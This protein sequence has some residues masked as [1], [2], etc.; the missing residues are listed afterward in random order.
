MQWGVGM[1][2]L[3]PPAALAAPRTL[4]STCATLAAL[5][6]LAPIFFSVR[7]PLKLAL[8]ASLSAMLR[9][10]LAEAAPPSMPALF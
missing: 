5:A 1:G 3:P 8:F 4:S 2:S 7:P 9:T 6:A 10:P